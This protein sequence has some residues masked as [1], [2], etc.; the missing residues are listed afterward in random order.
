MRQRGGTGGVT[1][2]NGLSLSGHNAQGEFADGDIAEVIAFDRAL[3]DDERRAL[4]SWLVVRYGLLL[5]P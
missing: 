4:E 2:P 5:G 1:P 3:T